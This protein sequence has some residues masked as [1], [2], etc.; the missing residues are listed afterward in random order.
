MNKKPNS[1]GNPSLILAAFTA[2][3]ALG[4][5][6]LSH[7]GV[8]RPEKFQW[9]WVFLIS[10]F[11]TFGLMPFFIYL[12]RRY[13]ILD[14]PM[15]RKDHPEPTPRLGGVPMF[16]GFL[17]ALC[18]ICEIDGKISSIIAT[19]F[20]V[21][22]VGLLEDIFGVKEWIRLLSQTAAFAIIANSGVVLHIFSHTPLGSIANLTITFLWI[23]GITNAMNFLDGM[24]GLASGV[25]IIISFFL[26]V[27]A[28]QTNQLP[29]L[30]LSVALIGSSLGFF[31]Y[32]FKKSGRALVFLG[33]AGSSFLGFVLAS[34]AILGEWSENDPLV[35]FSTP[36]LLFGVLIYDMSHTT[37]TRIFSGKVRDFL[38]LLT[39]VGKDHIHHRMETLLGSK[40]LAVFFIFL[41]NII[42]G[43]GTMALRNAKFIIAITLVVQA[44][45]IFSL[46]TILE[47][48]SERR[49]RD[50]K[51]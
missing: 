5:I 40:R 25:S 23:V 4:L 31:P 49:N 44:L 46:I 34:L 45:V 24:N 42:L 51:G 14:H 36:L 50:N 41:V 18:V 43:L 11:L 48:G 15:G 8:F 17:V 26:G 38:E 27:I 20:I 12:S 19:S 2:L 1:I 33:D 16:I 39:F 30:L 10:F 21:F 35:S 7:T 47:I 9:L 32:N 28:F 3:C 13:N 22:A 6:I 29:L 37:I